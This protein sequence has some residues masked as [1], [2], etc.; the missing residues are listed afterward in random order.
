M[1]RLA[2]TTDP[3]V[4]R[5]AEALTSAQHRWRACRGFG[6]IFTPAIPPAVIDEVAAALAP[7][8]RQAVEDARREGER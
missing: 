2:P 8:I 6:A 3:L 5:L 1:T 7:V 4:A